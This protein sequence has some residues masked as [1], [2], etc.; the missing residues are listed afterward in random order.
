M[1]F[2]GPVVFLSVLLQFCRSGEHFQ[3]KLNNAPHG[4]AFKFLQCFFL[5]PSS[6]LFGFF[7]IS[8]FFLLLFLFIF[9]FLFLLGF[10]GLLLLS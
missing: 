1:G 6:Y 10:F 7:S 4:F 8:C 5:F 2:S 3:A 9:N